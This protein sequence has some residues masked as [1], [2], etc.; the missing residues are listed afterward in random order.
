M[1]ATVLV[2]LYTNHSIFKIILWDRYYNYIHV[3]EEEIEAP[4]RSTKLPEVA[5]LQ[6]KRSLF[7][8]SM[9]LTRLLHHTYKENYKM[10]NYTIE[11]IAFL[12]L[13]IIRITYFFKSR[14]IKLFFYVANEI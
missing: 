13:L 2:A 12:V 3:T 1:P 14:E 4:K 6:L 9:F 7:L 5:Q 11:S 10:K 8:E